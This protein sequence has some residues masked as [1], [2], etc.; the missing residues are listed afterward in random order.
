MKKKI[1]TI[2]ASASFYKD[3]LV[4]E[5]KLQ[6]GG[7]VT[8]IPKIAYDMEK[9]NDF[10]VM[11]YKTWF[12]N[13]DD[14]TKKAQLMRDHIEKVLGGESILVMNM[15]KEGREGYIGANVL[16]E[17]AFAFYYHKPIF[18]FNKV[19]ERSPFYEEIVGMQPIVIDQD[20][21]NIVF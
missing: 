3:V 16:L 14:Y 8:Y 13:K 15:T 19:E 11:H 21:T 4:V 5:K 17:M 7:F 10:D 20:L 12:T 6:A 18:L 1:I 2:C 9:R